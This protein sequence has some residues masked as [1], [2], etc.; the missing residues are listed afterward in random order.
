MGGLAY[1]I[2]V[3]SPEAKFL[4]SFL[5]PFWGLGFGLGLGLGLVKISWIRGS[6]EVVYSHSGIVPGSETTSN[7]TDFQS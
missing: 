7:S 6:L 4:F 1:K 3:T 5:G 2:L